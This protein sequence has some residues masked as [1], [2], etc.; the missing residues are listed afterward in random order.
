MGKAVQLCKT[1]HLLG[2]RVPGQEQEVAL[3]LLTL[4]GLAFEKR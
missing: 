1:Q 2:D 3:L 4:L